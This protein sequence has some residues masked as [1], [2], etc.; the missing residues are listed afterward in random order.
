MSNLSSL[1]DAYSRK[2]RLFPGLLT[3][4]PI[5]ITAMAV[6]PALLTSSIGATLLTICTSCG[7]LYALSVFA[8]S[9]GKATEKRLLAVWGGWPTT[10]WLRHGDVNLDDLTRERYRTYLVANVPGLSLPTAEEQSADPRAADSRYAS[11]VKWLQEQ[12]RGRN[13]P[14]IEKENAEYGFRRN[15]RGM[16]PLGVTGCLF[17]LFTTIAVA[18][19]ASQWPP[20]SFAA[21][22]AVLKPAV[23]GAFLVDVVALCGWVFIVSDGWVKD[24]GNQYARALLAECD[25]K[26]G[27]K[28]AAARRPPNRKSPVK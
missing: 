7:L 20:A 18:A 27:G 17:A 19:W 16:K 24:A 11:G 23:A 5:V 1:F 9:R 12:C 28:V 3:I 13:F 2:A 6:F 10:A 26:G 15:L 21:L 25:A 14:L 8:R 4:F 22:V